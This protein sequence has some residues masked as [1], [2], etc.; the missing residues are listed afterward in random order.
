MHNQEP[1]A[2][3]CYKPMKL[4]GKTTQIYCPN[5]LGCSRFIDII[6]LKLTKIRYQPKYKYYTEYHHCTVYTN[7][8]VYKR[9]VISCGEIEDYD[10]NCYK[11]VKAK[12][13]TLTTA[14]RQIKWRLYTYDV[15]LNPQG[16]FAITHHSM[17]VESSEDMRD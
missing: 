4:L 9:C 5:Y 7:L 16:V 17:N 14:G 2:T 12:Q 8:P 13:Q 3:C 1:C 11:L 6:S 15:T 10:T